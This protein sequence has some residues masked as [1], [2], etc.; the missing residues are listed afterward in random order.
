M[1]VDSVYT[2]EQKANDEGDEYPFEIE[3][4]GATAIQVWLVQADGTR[5]QVQ[6][7]T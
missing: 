7:S 5:I 3:S 6:E 4:I 2:P 1:T